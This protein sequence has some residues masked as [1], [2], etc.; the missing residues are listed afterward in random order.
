MLWTELAARAGRL[1]A[2]GIQGRS[3][4]DEVVFLRPEKWGQARFDA[5]RQ[6]LV[7][8]VY[9]SAGHPLQLIMSHSPQTENAIRILERHDPGKTHGLVGLL[10]LESERLAVEPVAIHRETLVNLTLDDIPRKKAAAHRRR[11]GDEG[12]EESGPEVWVEA[13]IIASTTS[14]GTLLGRAA[15]QLEAIAEGGVRSARDVDR[16][17]ILSKQC[18][19]L[20]LTSLARPIARLAAE[21]DQLRKSL[22]G[23]ARSPAGTL[24]R[25]YYVVKFAIAQEVVDGATSSIGE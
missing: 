2:G 3:E 19:S 17:L 6:E 21:L 11:K 14:L 12:V 13:E 20:G 25:A 24:L 10:R 7:Q 15:E 9:D 22:D 5:V 4:Q 16:L 18:D 23:N 8:P 1:F